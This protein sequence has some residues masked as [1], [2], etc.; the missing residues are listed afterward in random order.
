MAARGE[1]W[2]TSQITVRARDCLGRPN[3]PPSI[4]DVLAYRGQDW[5]IVGLFMG[6]DPITSE[7]VEYLVLDGRIAGE[8]PVVQEGREDRARVF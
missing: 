1:F 7:V 2:M 5:M 3:R 4:G 8:R 6:T